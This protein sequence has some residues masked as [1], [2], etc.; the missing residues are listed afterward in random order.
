MPFL[1]KRFRALFQLFIVLLNNIDIS[2]PDWPFYAYFRNT[3]RFICTYKFAI[4]SFVKHSS[5]SWSEM[6]AKVVE[7]NEKH[8]HQQYLEFLTLVI[9]FIIYKKL[10]WNYTY[11]RLCKVQT[12]RAHSARG[13]F[14]WWKRNDENK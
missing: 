4:N 14:S 2:F 7:K 5:S 8:A 11:I 6:A 1:V 13:N 10:Y 12:K 3:A 9:L